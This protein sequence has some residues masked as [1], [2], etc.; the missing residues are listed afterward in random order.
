[1]SGDNKRLNEQF[2]KTVLDMKTNPRIRLKKSQYFVGLGANVN[3]QLY[4]KSVVSWAEDNKDVELAQFLR[5][6]G[7]KSWELSKQEREDLSKK[8]IDAI[9]GKQTDEAKDLIRSG[10]DL[11]Y[12]DKYG[13]TILMWLARYGE[14]KIAGEYFDKLGDV[15]AKNDDGVSALM[16]ASMNGHKKMVSYLI[17]KKADVNDKDKYNN[18]ALMEAS[19]K[20]YLDVVKELILNNAKV[21]DKSNQGLTA[22]MG[23]T[24]GGHEDVVKVLI[25]YGADVCSVDNQGFSAKSYATFMNREKL[26]KLLDAFSQKSYAEMVKEDKV[27]LESL[28]KLLKKIKG[29]D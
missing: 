15:N 27:K 3:S 9:K 14:L 21:N 8:L 2:V 18:T 23:A 4:G 7:G 16:W 12:R 22:L 20:G 5:E 6:K 28:S 24:I 1:M 11:R 29:R 26:V 25:V 13:N 19:A 10:A 17:D